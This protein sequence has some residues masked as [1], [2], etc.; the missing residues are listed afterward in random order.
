MYRTSSAPVRASF[1]EDE[2]RALEY[3]TPLLGFV[4]SATPAET[5]GGK[6]QLLDVG[7]GSGWS[8]YAFA[9]AGYDATGIDLNPAAF[10]PPSHDACRLQEGNAIQIP[11][12]ADSF[13]VV[14]CYQCLEH[15][16]DPG[17][18]LD[19]MVRVCRPGGAV[20]IVGPNLVSPFPAL[21]HASKPSSWSSLRLRRRPDTPRHPYG[22]TVPEILATSV[23]RAAQLTGKLI[24]R[25]PHFS[26]RAPDTVPPFTA[27]NDAC[28]LCNPTDLIAY[29]KSR[30]FRILLRGKPG[31]PPLTYLLA[32]GT[33]VAARK[34][35][36]NAGP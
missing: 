3:Y 18:A 33:W 27:D 28:Y 11:F 15:V 34:P 16:P 22:N 5:R 19:E 12:P 6:P 17:R 1:R 13:D 32:G 21:V 9:T 14:T 26:M 36:A 35:M 24:R 29:F 25:S 23:F 30:G 7:C 20:V 2:Q 31:R 10:E 8:T 4:S